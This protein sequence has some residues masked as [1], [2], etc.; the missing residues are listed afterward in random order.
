[1]KRAVLI[2]MFLLSLA[3]A[4]AQRRQNATVIVLTDTHVT[5]GNTN[6]SILDEAIDE[7]NRTKCDLVVIAGDVT[8]TGSNVEL[9]NIHRKLRRLRHPSVITTGNHETTWSESACAEFRRLWGHDGRMCAKAGGY[10]FVA[11]PSGPYMKMADG[12]IRTEDLAWI[13]RQMSKA[14]RRR[15]VG[16]C[17]Y[18]LNNDLANRHDIIRVIRRHDVA[19]SICGHYH[20]PRLMNFDSVPG[21]LCRS[22]MLPERDGGESFGYTILEFS[23]DSIL[24]NEKI[25]GERPQRQYAIRQGFSRELAEIESA[26]ATPPL[27]FGG[28]KAELVVSDRSSIYTGAAVG[29]GILYYGNSSGEF[30]AYDIRRGETKWVRRFGNTLYSTPVCTDGMVIV[31]TAGEGLFALD[32]E[33][34][35]VV[36]HALGRET[37]IGDCLLH[38]GALYT[39]C[40]GRMFRIN[41]ADGSIEWEF[42]FGSGQPQ[43]RP[44][45]DGNRL[46]FGAWDRHLYCIDTR[47]GKELWRWNNGSAN[48]LFSPGHI[49]PRISRGRVMIVAPDRHMTFID[50]ETGREIWREKRRR[51]RESTGLSDDGTTFYAKT[52]DGEMVAVPVSAESYEELWCADAGW[53]YDHNFCPVAVVGETAYMANRTGMVAAVNLTDGTVRHVA[54]LGNSSANDFHVDTEGAVWVTFIEGK[55]YR[56]EP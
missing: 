11:F 13:E 45:A 40:D 25:I 41:P 43:G 39:G 22:L 20:K 24:V 38:D 44:T 1:M 21:I 53:G 34:G 7:I 29:N 49:V 8:N 35:R 18:P 36:W 19:A 10:L 14:G 56:I 5:P 30:T 17:H 23:G 37:M 52:M 26:P 4:T 6:D 9:R 55:I 54:K 32:A 47:S 12:I 48:V 15:I 50:L 3:C 46:V 16:V 28:M 27:D 42:G 2:S 51:V 33:N 31:P